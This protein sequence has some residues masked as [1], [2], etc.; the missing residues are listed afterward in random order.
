MATTKTAT[1]ATTAAERETAN[2][3]EA[4]AVAGDERGL[5]AGFGCRVFRGSPPFVAPSA[6]P[7][8]GMDRCLRLMI[9]GS[10]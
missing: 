5:E 10:S 7:E 2:S 9:R 1:P 6:A 3:P 4:A 8:G